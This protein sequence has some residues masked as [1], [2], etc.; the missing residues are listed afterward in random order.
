MIFLNVKKVPSLKKQVYS[1]LREL[2]LNSELELGK[3]YSDQ[4]VANNFGVSRTPV[5]E[6]VLQL[7][8]ESLVDIVPYRGFIVKIISEAEIIDILQLR[9]SIEGYC[10]KK[11][12]Q[13]KETSPDTFK[14]T[15]NK[16]KKTILLQEKAGRNLDS[17]EFWDADRLLHESIVGHCNNKCF[18]D[19]YN[20]HRDKMK[21]I[22]FETLKDKSRIYSALTEHN[23]IIA[24][25]EK[26]SVHDAYEE[27]SRHINN[28][29]SLMMKALEKYNKE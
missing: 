19:I 21:I 14:K 10:I 5:R 29:R 22:G 16:L 17:K 12:M 15:L 23:A 27:T 26:G 20:S 7:Q 25:I 28:T 9:E 18:N 1:Y 8:H 3:L 24:A 2:I 13:C 6:A 4:W 11:L